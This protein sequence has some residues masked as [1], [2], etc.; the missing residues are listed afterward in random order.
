[1]VPLDASLLSYGLPGIALAAM[2]FVIRQ[3]Y[4]D[5]KALQVRLDK[6][7]EDRRLDAVQVNEKIVPVMSEFSLVASQVYT[8]LRAAKDK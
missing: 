3:L 1:M 6:A 8:K 2:A 5:N 7:Q 4:A